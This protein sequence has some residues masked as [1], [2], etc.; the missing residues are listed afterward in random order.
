MPRYRLDIEYDGG[1]YCGW[2]RQ[3]GQPSVQEAIEQAFGKLGGEIVSLRGAGRTDAGVHATGQ[4]A[5]ADLLRDWPPD[6]VRD[7]LNAHLQQAGEKIA[8]VSAVAVAE[9]FDA[10]FSALARHYV[11]RIANRRRLAG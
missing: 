3:A 11:Y 8:I 6:T 4:V 2:Q 7:A 5:H 9:S 10:R 1:P